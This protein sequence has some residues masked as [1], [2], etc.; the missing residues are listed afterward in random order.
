MLKKYS[1]TLQAAFFFLDMLIIGVSWIGAFYLRFYFGPIPVVKGIPAFED[2]FVLLYFLLPIYGIL[3]RYFGL[4]EPMRSGARTAEIKKVI[5][6]SLASTLVFITLVYLFRE[7]K[8]S[9]IVF[10][11]FWLLSTVF[12]CA[13]RYMLR[14][15]LRWFRMRGHNLRYVLIAGDGKLA[16]DV[17]LRLM[18]HGEYGFKVAGFV[19]KDEDQVGNVISGIP[20]VGTYK[21]IKNII[22]RLSADQLIIALPFD[23]MRLL[24]VILG[25]VAE[26]MVEI[27]IVPD[28]YQYFTLRKGIENLEGLPVINIRE[29]PLYGWNKLAK[30]LFDIAVSLSILVFLSPILFILAVAI[31][32]SSPG[33]IFYVQERMG[34]DGTIFNIIKFRSMFIWAEE[35]TGPQRTRKNDARRTSIGTFMRKFNLDEL[36]QFI[37]VLKGE[38]SIVGPRPERE[39]FMQ[40]FKKRVPEYMLRHT[41]KAGI[42]GWAQVNG[43]RGETDIEERTQFDL[44]YIEHWSMWFDLKI[45]F[46]SFIAVKN[47][48]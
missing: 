6:A 3:F 28:L 36:P 17:A 13:F 24:K 31:K 46:R 26:E 40:E 27:K 16:Q 29:S 25:Q 12:L 35:G 39:A 14:S 38:M 30:R 21:D 1:Q 42:T 45:F 47:A 44:Y 10:L 15:F 4:Y 18:H 7:Y 33:P 41:M 37:N 9:R 5:T 48:Y 43:L 32:L 34:L 19:S 8:Y 23:Q 20:V 11:Y 22:V 2:F